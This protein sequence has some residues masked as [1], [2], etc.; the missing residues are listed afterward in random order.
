MDSNSR[1]IHAQVLTCYKWLVE[2]WGRNVR[3]VPLF[4]DHLNLIIFDRGRVSLLAD[5]VKYRQ[6]LGVLHPIEGDTWPIVLQMVGGE[7][8]EPERCSEVG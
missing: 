5:Q 3:L 1:K 6:L 7:V 2:Q 8:R 4:K